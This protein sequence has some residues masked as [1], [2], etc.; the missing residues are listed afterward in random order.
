MGTGASLLSWMMRCITRAIWS[1]L[2]PAAEEVMISTVFSGRHA[3]WARA[4]GLNEAPIAAA[5]MTNVLRFISLSPLVC[6][7]FA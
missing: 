6:I 7:F 2:P 5:A 3:A 1:L 4:P